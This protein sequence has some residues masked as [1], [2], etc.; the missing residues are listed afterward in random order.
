MFCPNCGK[1]CADSNFCPECGTQIR[2]LETKV[3]EKTRENTLSSTIANV[4]EKWEGSSQIPTSGGYLGTN[5]SLVLFDSALSVCVNT[6]FKKIRTQIPY[7]QLTTVIYSRPGKQYA[8]GALLLRG[9]GNKNIPIPKNLM[10]DKCAIL[11]PQEKDTLFYHIFYM[12]KAVAPRSTRF[13]MITP[14]VAKTVDELAKSIDMEYFFRYAPHRERTTDA[15]CA[16]HGIP[17]ETARALVN[18]EFDAWQVERYKEDPLEAIRDL[19]L[20][21]DAMRQREYRNNQAGAERRKRQEQEAIRSSLERLERIK[22]IEML[23]DYLDRH[24][25]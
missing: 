20:V 24:N 5:G 14:P 22:T 16:K 10:V 12:L 15:I 21:V 4:G 23:D 3:V 25:R 17:K 8:S 1:D 6:L 13:E 2:G 9:E 19:N 18:A 11:F 7:N